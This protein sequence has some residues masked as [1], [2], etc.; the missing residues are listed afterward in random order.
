MVTDSAL[1]VV[2]ECCCA[3]MPLGACRIDSVLLKSVVLSK[4]MCKAFLYL[5]HTD[6]P[7]CLCWGESPKG[8]FAWKLN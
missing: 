1:V 4:P 2:A 5:F 7:G 8:M 6:F 3:G